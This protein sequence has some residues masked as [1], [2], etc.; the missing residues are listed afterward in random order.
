MCCIKTY[1][2]PVEPSSGACQ[3]IHSGDLLKIKE[4]F[5]VYGLNKW[6]WENVFSLALNPWIFPM[7]MSTPFP[8]FQIS[9][10]PIRGKA[11]TITFQITI[12]F[13]GFLWPSDP[14]SD[15]F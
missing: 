5:I 9:Q 4:T 14:I 3:E 10:F 7:R 8:T 2:L 11:F 13:G 12:V 6:F 15:R 1:L